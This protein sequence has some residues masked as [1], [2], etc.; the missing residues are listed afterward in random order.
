MIY[1]LAPISPDFA[2][3]ISTWTYDSFYD[4]YDFSGDHLPGIVKPEYRYHVVL[5]ENT[6]LVGF[7]CFGEDA[8]VPGGD[9]LGGEPQVL[10]LGVGLRPDLTGQ[11]FGQDF[12]REVLAFASRTYQPDSFRVT[13]A[14]FNQ[15]SLK[16]FQA[17][18][19]IETHTFTRDQVEIE[20]IQL[21]SPIKRNQ[22]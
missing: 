12:V 22:V 7:C 13:V 6:E 9:Y 10:D 4:L 19:F 17:L 11:G 16:T 18:G 2:Q 8:R 14:S 15:R 20:F 3:Q 5:D 21:E 1:S